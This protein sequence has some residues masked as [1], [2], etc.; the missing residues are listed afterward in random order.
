MSNN[1]TQD[2]LEAMSII[3]QNAVKKANYDKTIQATIISCV[4]ATIGKYKVNYQDGSWFA[5]STNTNIVYQPG[6]LVYILVPGNDMRNNKTILGATKEVGINYNT[7][8][9]EGDKYVENGNNVLTDGGTHGLCSYQTRSITLYS[10]TAAQEDNIINIDTNAVKTYINT[11]SHFMTSADFQTKLPVEQKYNG[12]YG[13][14]FYLDFIDNAEGNLITRTYSFDI[15]I[16]EGNPYN[17]INKIKQQAVFEVDG[18]NFEKISRIELFV[19]GFPHQRQGQPQ[20][21]FISNITFTGANSITQEQLNGIALQLIAPKG[22]I[23]NEYSLDTDVRTINA[24]VRVLG[25]PV[26]DSQAVSYYW[27]VRDS[28][29]T[30]SNQY[31]SKYGGQG[32]K[33]LNTFTT[34]SSNPTVVN[35]NSG[36]SSF[37][38]KKSDTNIKNTK[39]KCVAIYQGSIISKDFSIINNDAA[40]NIQIESDQGTEF[41]LDA[42]YP[43]LTCIV[44]GG[45]INNFQYVWG[46]T[47]NNGSFTSL[48]SQEQAYN[49][50]NNKLTEFNRLKNGFESGTILKNAY[51]STNIKNID[52]YNQLINQLNILNKQQYVFNNQIIH[53]NVKNITNFSTFSCS[54]FNSNHELIGNAAITLINKTTSDGGYSLIINNGTQLFNYDENGISPASSFNENPLNISALDFSLF[55]MN[56]QQVDIDTIKASNIEWKIPIQDTMLVDKIKVGGTLSADGRYLIYKNTKIFN[57]GIVEKYSIDKSENNIELKINYNGYVIIAKTNFTFT[58]QGELGTNG[59]GIVVK[60][61]PYNSNNVAI[62]EYP[63]ATTTTGNSYTYNFNN[64]RVQVWRN[65]ELIFNGRQTGNSTEGKNVNI[66]WSILR[67]KYSSSVYD[68]TSFTISATNGQ[69]GN[70]TGMSLASLYT[71]LNA[72]RPTSTTALNNTPANIIKAAV[73][74]EDVTHYATLS[75]ITVYKNDAAAAYGATLIQN[76]GFRYVVYGEDGRY[77]QYDDHSPFKIKTT[78]Q[79]NGGQQDISTSTV[80]SY[81]PTYSFGYLGQYYDNGSRKSQIALGNAITPAGS[82]KN[83][84]YVKPAQNFDGLCVTNALYA[85]VK[86]GN[87]AMLVHIPIHF[88][89]NKYGHAP[90]ND[91]DGNSVSVDSNG[92]GVILA[93]QVG[94]GKK[95]SDNSFT[96]ILIGSVKNNN[97]GKTQDGLFG[98]AGGV[99]SVFLDADTGKAEFGKTGAG[100]I[101]IDPS[102][103]Q[104]IL[105]SGNYS[106]SA[107]MQIN[108]TQPEIRFGSGHFVVD[109]NGNLVATGGG[110]IAGWNIGSN[111]LT[112]GTVGISSNN[113]A[114]TNIAFWAGNASAASA[115]FSVDYNGSLKAS[116]GT[117]GSGSGKINIGGS[118]SNSSIY[119]GNHSTLGSTANGFYLGTDGLSL[120]SNFSVNN[121]GALTA[122]S[123]YIGNGTS[124]FTISNS[125]IYNKKGGYS[126]NTA[127]VYLG[128]DGIGLGAGNF[129]VTSAGALHATSGDIGGWRLTSNAIRSANDVTYMGGKGM[130]F[131]SSGLSM[132]ANFH[133]DSN[134]N[135]YAN[136]GEFVG[137]VNASSGKI[138][139][140]TINSTSLT[141]GNTTISSSGAMSGNKWSITADGKAT[142]ENINI[143]GGKMSGGTISG[144]SRTGGSITGGSINPGGVSCPGYSS[145]NDWC[146]GKIHA[147][148]AW[149]GTLIANK[150]TADYISS[151]IAS[152][153]RLNVKS[154]SVSG[155]T[156]TKN[157]TVSNDIT[158]GG[159]A[160]ATATVGNL[161]FSHGILTNDP[162]DPFG[163]SDYAKTSD[164]PSKSSTAYTLSTSRPTVSFTG[165]TATGE[166][167]S[168]SITIPTSTITYYHK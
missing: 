39:Y 88:M 77:P 124:G 60:I 157:L 28:S 159:K 7:I 56:G 53:V 54:V 164:V 163:L 89:L 27:F 147:E 51:Y 11:S 158:V 140:W 135:L 127:G 144:G 33:C 120:G 123:G 63:V 111:A 10:A 4:D 15:D 102:N 134:G 128:T 96:G 125:A 106:G 34:I 31:Y 45:N 137:K 136:N 30:T 1:Y 109:K 160:G 154:M 105:K 81:S 44:S 76:S 49:E 64:L 162:R 41:I 9:D 166:K 68:N 155:T 25:K 69:L 116:A 74:Y 62:N 46:V 167:V 24:Q 98:Y 83:E 40:Y 145:M 114:N 79:L 150:I 121:Q 67:N 47:D 91:W 94:A 110:T 6:T 38:V 129:Y 85:I 122:K 131:G 126:N 97:N 73:V 82:A 141:G 61:V 142:F 108:L 48:V 19:E 35:F 101:I 58:K 93:P 5:Y 92:N 37:S 16:M 103:N 2:L 168:G 119:S 12:N 165:T 100:Q 118:G 32:W 70:N 29:V 130:Y 52:K 117:I 66:V 20:D 3:A 21:I 138:A 148:E 113:S 50:Y 78:M 115:P 161:T 104:A 14:R 139:G 80:S 59:T 149:I 57:Y 84:K 75:I 133:V 132:G 152:L 107:G 156:A 13:I 87:A 99:R 71:E 90:L 43:T 26:S 151:K 143:T 95:N 42:G 36:L 17:Y 72:G 86:N 23:F 22:Y 146:V 112:K 8:L 153:T 55:D 65:G 18:V